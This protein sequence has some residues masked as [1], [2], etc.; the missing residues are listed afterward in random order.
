MDE[1]SEKLLESAMGIRAASTQQVV[2]SVDRQ[3]SWKNMQRAMKKESSTG[4]SGTLGGC[5]SPKSFVRQGA[6]LAI[7]Y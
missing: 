4:L 3:D 1:S 6:I 7:L 5:L 2:E